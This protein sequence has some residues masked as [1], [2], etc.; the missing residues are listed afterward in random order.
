MHLERLL[1]KPWACILILRK[2]HTNAFD[3]PPLDNCPPKYHPNEQKWSPSP[4]KTM[5]MT[6]WN[7]I[8]MNR[9][10]VQAQEDWVHDT[11]EYHPNEQKWSPSPGR[12]GA[13]HVG[14]SSKWTEMKSKPLEDWV[15]DT[16]EYHPNEQK[17]SPSPG[18]PG[19]WHVGI[20]SK[21][22]EMKSKPLEDCVHDTL[23]WLSCICEAKGHSGIFKR[24]NG[25]MLTVFRMSSLLMVAWWYPLTKSILESFAP[26]KLGVKSWKCSTGY[27]F[28]VVTFADNHHK[29]SNLSPWPL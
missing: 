29:A 7:I 23:E 8:Q 5:C 9:N 16:M 25:V 11:L 17:W 26:A 27:F 19:A 10:E 1:T 2:S 15:H 20:S 18:R 24:S 28:G 21:W 13:W 12:L 3:I 4:W 6:R 14:I 22:T